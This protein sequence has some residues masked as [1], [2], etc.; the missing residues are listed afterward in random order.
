MEFCRLGADYVGFF[1]CALAGELGMDDRTISCASCDSHTPPIILPMQQPWTQA[2]R[3]L[4]QKYG[5]LLEANSDVVITNFLG[6]LPRLLA[7]ATATD[8]DLSASNMLMDGLKTSLRRGH[9][10]IG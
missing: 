3:Q 9:P 7:H 8:L 1:A 2:T 4:W 10:L 5:F 6:A